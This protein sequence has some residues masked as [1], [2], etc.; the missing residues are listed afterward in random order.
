[1][2]TTSY[3]FNVFITIYKCSY[4]AFNVSVEFNQNQI[5]IHQLN[6]TFIL[7][8]IFNRHFTHKSILHCRLK[9]H[10]SYYKIYFHQIILI[11]VRYL[12]DFQ[13]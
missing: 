2:I 6:I 7:S 5:K 4:I 12:T 3:D 9:L 1:M 8:F 10:T 11:F 13:N